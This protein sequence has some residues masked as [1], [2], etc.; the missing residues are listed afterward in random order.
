[1]KHGPESWEVA[2]S[3]N[4]NLQASGEN[5]MANIATTTGPKIEKNREVEVVGNSQK[6]NSS[7][8]HANMGTLKKY[9]GQILL[10]LHRKKDI[11]QG[12]RKE[13]K[14]WT[15]AGS[16]QSSYC[17]GAKKPTNFYFKII[18]REPIRSTRNALGCS[19]PSWAILRLSNDESSVLRIIS[20]TRLNGSPGDRK[21]IGD[22]RARRVR[23]LR[24][25][26]DMRRFP[27]LH[28]AWRKRKVSNQG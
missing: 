18:R 16:K 6:P 8:E 23:Y 22:C 14:V 21:N 10:K 28:L 19:L 2:L 15:H 1:M 7:R 5:A 11:P 3:Q 12:A 26:K 9:I 25:S 20:E 24:G 4:Q 27:K 13:W 17:H